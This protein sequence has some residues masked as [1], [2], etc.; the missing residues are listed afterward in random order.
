MKTMERVVRRKI[1]EYLEDN[2]KLN[3]GQHGFRKG[4]SC[5]SQLLQHCDNLLENVK[6]GH[7]VDVIYLDFAKAFDTV[8]HDILLRKVKSLGIG[9]RIGI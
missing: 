6:K 8:D 9:G 2:N 5:V 4:R 1:V 7:N 3:E